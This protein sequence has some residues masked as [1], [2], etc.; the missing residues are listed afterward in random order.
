M[1]RTLS[2]VALCIAALAATPPALASAYPLRA[3]P[4]FGATV[5]SAP[6]MVKVW[7]D[8]G[9][10]PVYSTL[11]VTDATGNPVSGGNGSVDPKDHTIL[12]TALTPGLPAGTYRVQWSALAADG[13]RTSGHF[14]FTVE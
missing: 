2:R 9:V 10:E 5:A 12:E 13:N 3:T 1:N 6:S 8:R 7:F 11:T 14:T 4:A